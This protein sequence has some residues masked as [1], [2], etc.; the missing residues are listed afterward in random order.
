MLI[1]CS[2]CLLILSFFDSKD[3]TLTSRALIFL[4]SPG[5]CISPGFGRTPVA[6]RRGVTLGTVDSDALAAAFLSGA[7]FAATAFFATG[8]FFAVDADVASFTGDVFAVVAF[9]VLAMVFNPIYNGSVD[10]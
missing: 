9:A 3:A 6:L 10:V 7:F 4:R 5:E 8:F 1:A 2:S